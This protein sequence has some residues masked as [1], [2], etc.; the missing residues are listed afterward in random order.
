[1]KKINKKTANYCL[2]IFCIVCF[3]LTCIIVQKEFQD[4]TKQE[5]SE[6][7][8][9]LADVAKIS[10]PLFKLEQL[11][12]G[13]AKLLS[14]KYVMT[15]KDGLL[16]IDSNGSI[17]KQYTNIYMNWLDICEEEK[18]IVYGNFNKEIGICR[19]NDNYEILSNDIILNIQEDLGIDPAVCK[20]G[21]LYYMTVTHITGTINNA[22]VNTENGLYEVIL[23]SSSDLK[24]WSKVSSVIKVNQNIEDIDLNYFDNSLYLTYEKEQCDKGKSSINLLISNDNG[25]TWGDNVVLIEENADN[26]PASFF[27]A[28]N[29]YYLYYSSDIEQPGSTYEGAK[30]YVQKYDKNFKAENEP[31]KIPLQNSDGNLLYDVKIQNELLYLLF[32]QNYITKSNLILEQVDNYK[33]V[34]KGGRQ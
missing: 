20:A 9:V 31:I 15:N 13:D 16:I 10:K 7:T 4:K 8:E 34:F 24:N 29:G 18:M 11:W 14:N 1:M 19:Y 17:V 30:V 33:E 22:D 28:E 12:N 21:S 2:F 6:S 26:E 32:S 25:K 3:I 23:Y 27:Q 5:D